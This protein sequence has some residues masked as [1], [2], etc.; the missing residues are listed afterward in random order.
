MGKA[1]EGQEVFFPVLK[2]A[3][4]ELQPSFRFRAGAPA[5]G[6]GGCPAWSRPK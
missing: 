6:T 4:I 5:G 1:A 3:E 2:G